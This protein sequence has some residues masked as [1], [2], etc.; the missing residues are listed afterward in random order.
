MA[1]ASSPAKDRV[2][3]WLQE[4]HQKKPFTNI[5]KASEAAVAQFPKENLKS[6]T[7]RNWVISSIPELKRGSRGG[8]RKGGGA[9]TP[10]RGQQGQAQS[11]EQLKN[12]M[13]MLRAQSVNVLKREWD[14]I[15]AK[16]QELQELE[17]A[18]ENSVQQASEFSGRSVQS[19]K[20]ELKK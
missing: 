4:Q 10:Q 14:Q 8:G 13:E 2:S 11:L 18:F 1:R 12:Q 16:R 20:Q 15:Q 19:I 6:N 5:A 9:R 17:A 3:N 7:V